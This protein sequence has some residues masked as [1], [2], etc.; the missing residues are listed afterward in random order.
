MKSSD[1]KFI[2]QA[3][4]SVPMY[5][6][7]IGDLDINLDDITQLEELPTITKEEIVRQDSIIAANCIPLLY[8]NKLIA[9]KTSG[10]TGKYMDV[11][12]KCLSLPLVE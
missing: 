1:K 11:I 12:G 4:S 8:A 5:V 3:Y 7:L 2:K 9:K 10:S 6:E